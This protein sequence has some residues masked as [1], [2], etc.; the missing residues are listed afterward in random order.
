MTE[1]VKVQRPVF[2]TD[3]MSPWLMY[4]REKKHMVEV[5][6]AVIPAHVKEAMGDDPKA[7]FVGAWS[8]VVG[9]GLSERVSD[10]QEW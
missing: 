6:G 4:D 3:P 5:P 8:S 1:I 7:Y 2:T 9:W 10:Q